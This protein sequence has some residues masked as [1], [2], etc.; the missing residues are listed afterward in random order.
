MSGRLVA[1]STTTPSTVA[2][3]S[4]SRKSC[5]TNLDSCGLSVP[6]VVNMA[7]GGGGGEA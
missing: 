1:P 2:A 3:M 5:D 6:R 7:W 4:I